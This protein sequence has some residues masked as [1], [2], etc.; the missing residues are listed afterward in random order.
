MSATYVL[1]YRLATLLAGAGA[2]YIADIIDWRSAYFVM[3]ASTSVGILTTLF[4]KEPQRNI[5]PQTRALEQNLV[6]QIEAEVKVKGRI[7]TFI[8]WFSA[9]V[10]SPFAEFF[11]RTGK[12]AIII[13]LLIA[14]Y[15][16]TDI[17][18]AVMA[19]PFYLDLGFSKSEIASV[20]KL[21]G[22]FLTIGGAALGGVLVMRYGIMRILLLGSVMVIS[23]NLLFA[24]LS[25]L[26]HNID[27]LALVISADSLAG[28]IATAVFIAYLSSLTNTAYT[29]TQYALFSSLMTLFPKI[30]AGFSGI[31][32]DDYGYMVFYIYA[33]L[34]GIPALLAILYLMKKPL[35]DPP[36]ENIEPD[37]A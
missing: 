27:M 24:W 10:I 8:E 35:L 13:L 3:A 30:I 32:V 21:F 6:E 19:N 5:S 9:A 11:Q 25:T 37:D 22:F 36:P 12:T 4:M 14:T 20:T 2:L 1:G 31:V 23:S 33:S 34:L 17:T 29:A 7:Q 26:G 28:G 15:R 18:M 16:I